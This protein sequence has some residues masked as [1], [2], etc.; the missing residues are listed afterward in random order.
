MSRG[1][2]PSDFSDLSN[3]A[4]DSGIAQPPSTST[5]PSEVSMT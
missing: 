5:S 2:Y 3:T 4:R 1:E